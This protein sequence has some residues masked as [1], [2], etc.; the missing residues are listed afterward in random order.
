MSGLLFAAPADVS[1]KSFRHEAFL[2]S[3]DEQFLA[4]ATAFVR[5]ALH[6]GEAVLV[7]VGDP[8]ATLLRRSL[9][10]D[11][12]Q[13][14][15][16]DMARLG[17][18]PARLIPE[19]RDWVQQHASAQGLRAIGEP[20]RVGGAQGQTV[21]CEHHEHLLNTA[22]DDGPSWWLLCPYDV[23]ALPATVTESAYASHPVVIDGDARRQSSGYN[24][25]AHVATEPLEEPA[26]PVRET[27]FDVKGL[28][29]LRDMVEEFAAPVVGESGTADAVLVVSELATNSIQYGGGAGTLRLWRD[30]PTLVCEVRDG[31]VITDPLVGRRRPSPGVRGKAG[32]WIVN[33]VCELVQIRSAP[34]RGTVVRVRVVAR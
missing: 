14:D 8:H 12:E 11:A 2:Y 20:V 15:F 23:A 32:L 7:A 6:A 1:V 27:G 28:A 19:W 3:G 5:S 17:R 9:G 33:Q 31:G 26:G 34:E 21:E 30:G 22:F 18:N 16:F 4:G 10:S 24:S 25:S 29:A 13:V